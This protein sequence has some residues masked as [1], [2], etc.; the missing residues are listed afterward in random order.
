MQH[1][2]YPKFLR[3]AL[4]LCV[5][6][7][8]FSGFT[9]VNFTANDGIP[10]YS[11]HF[12][13]G[14]NMGFL[15]LGWSNQTAADLLA[16]NPAKGIPG[17]GARSLRPSLA[18]Y[19]LEQFGDEIE[20]EPF[21]YYFNL[22]MNDLTA[23]VGEP[24][25]ALRDTTEYCPGHQS[26]MFKNLYEPIW[27]NGENGTPIN[28]NN[29]FAAYMYG[30]VTKYD[31][32]VKFW[33]IWNEPGYTYTDKGWRPPGYPG[34]Y[35]ENNPDPCDYKL[36]APVFHYLRTLRIAYEVIKYVSPDDYV[37]V[38]GLGF[39][40][41]LDVLLR[42][43]D[44]PID[45]S[46]TEQYPHKG[47][48]YF[49]VL[50]IHSYPSI[51]GSLRHWDDNIQDWAYMRNSDEAA[52]Q[53]INNRFAIYEDVLSTYGYNGE[54]YPKKLRTITE[55][56]VPRIK[57]TNE[58]LASVEGQTNFLMKAAMTNKVNDVLQMHV[59]SIDDLE[60]ESD[61]VN[62][63]Q[64]MGFYK[65]FTN[66]SP[67]SQVRHPSAIGY[68]TTA[69]FI[70]ETTYDPNR[71]AALNLPQG[72]KGYAFKK[73][74]GTYVYALWAKTLIDNSEVASKTYSFPA[75][76]KMGSLTRYNWDYSDTQQSFTVDATDIP[77]TGSP[78]FF[79]EIA[80]V[81][82][83]PEATLST[84]QL[85][86]TEPFIVT[87]TF[88]EDVTGMTI[89]DFV[90]TNGHLSDFSGNGTTYSVKVT[91]IHSG[92]IT[93]NLPQGSAKDN[94]QQDNVPTLPLNMVYKYCQP[95]GNV[96]YAWITSVRLKYLT[97]Y[98]GKKVYNDFTDFNFTIDR[99]EETSVKLT[100]QQSVNKNGF[101]RAWIDYN[102]DGSYAENE[103]AFQG[104]T[105]SQQ[106]SLYTSFHIPTTALSGK[107]RMRIMFSLDDY[108]VGPCTSLDNGEVEDYSVT[109]VG[110]GG[111]DDCILY[112][113][114]H[115]S[116]CDDMGTPIYGWDD[117]F[118][119]SMTVNGLN[120]SGNWVANING[121]TITGPYNEPID[122]GPY[123]IHDN[124][125]TAYFY[126]A[127]EPGCQV[128]TYII[129]PPH[130]SNFQ[131]VDTKNYC[132]PASQNPWGE[133]I[134]HVK[135]GTIDNTSYR[136]PYSDF[137]FHS[138]DV[139]Q[140]QTYW[141]SLTSGFGYYTHDEYWRVWIDYNQNEIFET[142]E[143]AF[144]KMVPAPPN[145]T[146][147]NPTFGSITIPA[148]AQTGPTLMRIIM[149]RNGFADPCEDI[150]FG[151][152]E[153]Y[154]VNIQ[155]IPVSNLPGCSQMLTPMDNAVDVPLNTPLAWTTATDADGY[156]LTVSSTP[157]G[158][159]ILD[160]FDVG[161][162][163]GF[164]LFPFPH[165]STFYVKVT[166]YN[167]NGENDGCA[168]S[169]FTTID[170]TTTP[171]DD[172]P[173]A[174]AGFDYLGS[175]NNHHYFVSQQEASWSD[176][177]SMAMNLGGHLAIIED[178]NEN[179]FIQ[180]HLSEIA[181]IGLSDHAAE[182]IFQWV[183][184]T[185]PTYTN[186][187]DCSWCAENSDENDYYTMFPWDGTWSLDNTWAERKYVLEF[188]CGS[189]P[190]DNCTIQAQVT[191]IQCFDNDTPDDASD[192]LFNFYVPI[193]GSNDWEIAFNGLTHSGT[194]SGASFGP[195][196]ISQFAPNQSITLTVTD[197]NITNCQAVSGFQVPNTCSSGGQTGDVDLSLSI[198]ASNMNPGQWSFVTTYLTIENSGSATANNVV[199]DYFN[200][201]DNANWSILGFTSYI[202]PLGTE[203]HDWTGTWIIPSI[204][205]NE[206]L[207]LEYTGF[208]K[209]ATAI[210]MFA[211]VAECDELDMDSSPGNNQ[212]QIPNE[213]DEA[214]IVLNQAS[215]VQFTENQNLT[216]D[217]RIFPN[218]ASDYVMVELPLE[219]PVHLRI[220]NN[221][222][223]MVFAQELDAEHDRL[224]RISLAE[225]PN[226]AYMIF[227]NGLAR[228]L[229]KEGF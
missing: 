60:Y 113:N 29:Y 34:N 135:F 5:F 105:N 156:K 192:D 77:L 154:S 23:F 31:N 79:T 195:F 44:N 183:N 202:E 43:T 139:E 209:V 51:D 191:N 73:L 48:A 54:I 68:K 221:L 133:W 144:E 128:S 108:P 174:L 88:N 188:D 129:P 57:F 219:Q 178:Q 140:N 180:D 127:N 78:S 159:D 122:F 164:Q 200:Q 175:Y 86:V 69:D 8:S 158:H 152:I 82:L 4:F 55:T 10:A 92:P 166:P 58:S 71:T 114:Q 218:P 1:F 138:A 186:Y 207:T 217:F 61:I 198:S 197:Q 215:G 109:I 160:N 62:E 33:E 155:G 143:I 99:A 131:G 89:D 182:G 111:Q 150:D 214:L 177:S 185:A 168:V 201:S 21:E 20:L 95:K 125:F 210:P 115:E 228:T 67:Q 206:S 72:V 96:T 134:N 45:G 227:A 13:P 19:V 80:K 163:T 22:G 16:G 204:A 118:S 56:N 216:D 208:T 229:I 39:P 121:Q 25:D 100:A 9:Q 42:N 136:K 120:S 87:A 12:R 119:I 50:G 49:D 110:E 36:R 222:G 75:G 97:K 126:D 220:L 2:Y 213:D 165:H 203:Y 172:C 148:T 65:K 84:P 102:Q 205:P 124:E 171:T 132:I 145:G 151:E 74:N 76:L 181:F 70:T 24:S 170:T 103:I 37:V 184:N 26:T 116:Y 142:S 106:G 18:S 83:P 3:V 199:V 157:D 38:A 66:E 17:V 162:V 167:E 130:C 189:T 81:D 64:C 141:I 137:S 176:A 193:S 161:D 196:N 194:G 30:L 47:G 173:T 46:V 35:W 107:T 117:E 41:F 91:P 32:Y 53:V 93:I 153:D 11:G 15:P 28:D 147:E 146:Y 94:A 179:D 40:S 169:Q 104:K 90:V 212:T 224:V 52:K 7:W 223:Q 225:M 6:S 190:P 149:S 211:Q 101:F 27:D 112:V 187:S 63:F 123:V 14:S 85:I 98:S 226:G 59:Y